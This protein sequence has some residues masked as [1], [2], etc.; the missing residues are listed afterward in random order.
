MIGKTIWIHDVNR[1]RYRKK[2]G[3]SYGSPIYRDSFAPHEIVDET[4]VSWISSRGIKIPKC[5]GRGIC[6]TQEEVSRECFVKDN[7]Y[8]IS[9]KV[10]YLDYEELKNVADIIGYEEE[11]E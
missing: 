7:A 2:D 8:K 11:I 3:R 10:R 1:R 9:E 5:G 6:F 4:R